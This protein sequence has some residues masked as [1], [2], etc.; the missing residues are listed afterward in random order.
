VSGKVR[1]GGH[2]PY[3]FNGFGRG[4]F[5]RGRETRAV[6]GWRSRHIWRSSWTLRGGKRKAHI[7]GIGDILVP[8]R[9]KSGEDFAA[10]GTGAI[11]G[12]VLATTVDAK[13]SG[14]IP[15]TYD[16]LLKASF[17]TALVSRSVGRA[18]MEESADRA[19]LCLFFA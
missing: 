15:A 8:G 17:R 14:G 12:G 3:R 4:R 11:E 18:V 16:R 2:A 5:A 10:H 6:P 19:S 1:L 7:G 13:S 9:T